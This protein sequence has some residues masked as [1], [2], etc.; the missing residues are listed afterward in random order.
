[1]RITYLDPSQPDQAF[2]ALRLALKEPNGLLAIGGCLSPQRLINAYRH[3]AFPWF[4]QGE[5]ILWWSPD[6][7]LVLFPDNLKVSRSLN[8]TLRKQAFEIHYD[9]AFEQVI[10]ACSAPRQD[11]AGTWITED[12]KQAYLALHHLGIAHSVEAW[13][14]NQLVGGL[15]GVAIGRVFFGESMFHCATDAS[16]VA[17][18]HL[19]RQLMEWGYELIDCQVSSK[20]LFTLGAEEISRIKFADLLSQLCDLSP[21]S[22]TWQI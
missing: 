15:Y 11:A 18:V 6:P 19:V 5:P 14:D 10:E 8:K 13:F 17:F 4:S 20:H 9:R 21:H 7:R 1:M 2:P 22:Q 16:K 3:G 12:M